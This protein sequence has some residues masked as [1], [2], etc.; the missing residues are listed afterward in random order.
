MPE[1]ANWFDVVLAF[2]SAYLGLIICAGLVSIIVFV[3]IVVAVVRSFRGFDKVAKTPATY[4][5]ARIRGRK[6][7][8]D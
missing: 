6:I 7:V 5:P 8:R 3:A 2:L 4:K 1:V